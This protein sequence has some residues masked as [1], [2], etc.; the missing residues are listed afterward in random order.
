[1]KHSMKLAVIGLG[2][3]GRELVKRLA[4]EG[5]EV[6]AVDVSLEIVES[7]A[8]AATSAVALDS[9]DEK[10]MR[11]LNL[12]DMDAVILASSQSFET[13]IVTADLLRKIGVRRIFARYRTALH[14][15]ILGMLGIADIFNPEERA[16]A[17]MAESF[18]HA[19]FHQTI[20]V[21]DSFQVTELEAP[22]AYGGQTLAESGLRSGYGLNALALKRGDGEKERILIPG[23]DTVLRAGDRLLVFARDESIDRFV[24]EHR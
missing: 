18:S 23:D 14:K 11:T 3:F 24:D 9:T 15:R 19:G 21:W 8:D 4:Q 10:A 13:L 20:R 17:N 2:D 16:A 7:L 12:E 6:L 22:A 5:H 1:M